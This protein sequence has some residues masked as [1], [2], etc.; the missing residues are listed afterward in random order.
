M[1]PLGVFIGS[2]IFPLPYH[3]I[4]YTHSFSLSLYKKI[5]SIASVLLRANARIKLRLLGSFYAGSIVMTVQW[6]SN[7]TRLLC[8]VHFEVYNRWIR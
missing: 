3:R 4:F 6:L 8:V 2:S 1:A 7:P 5:S